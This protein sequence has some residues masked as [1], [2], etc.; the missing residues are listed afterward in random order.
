MAQGRIV[1]LFLSKENHLYAE[2][3]TPVGATVTVNGSSW[4]CSGCRKRRRE[5][6][7]YVESAANK[8][9]NNCRATHIRREDHRPAGS[10]L[11]RP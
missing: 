10:N 3:R 5:G 2:Y 4:Q 8:H 1:R 6:R 11:T 7:R 9:A